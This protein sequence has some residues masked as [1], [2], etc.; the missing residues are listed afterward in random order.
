MKNS[1][2]AT[3]I[4]QYDL[5]GHIIAEHES[6]SEAART[7]KCSFFGLAKA[8]R[9]GKP[10]YQKWIFR[11]KDED[12]ITTRGILRNKAIEEEQKLIKKMKERYNRTMYPALYANTFSFVNKNEKITLTNALY[13]AWNWGKK[14]V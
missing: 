9:K 13:S 8:L 5:T 12:R 11:Y 10:F 1:K 2:N 4:I 14:V 7:L 3:P 6:I